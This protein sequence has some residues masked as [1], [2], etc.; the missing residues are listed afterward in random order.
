MPT[1]VR[2]LTT[3]A[4]IAAFVL[5]VMALLIYFVEPRRSEV[6]IE[7]PLRNLQAEPQDGARGDGA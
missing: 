3:I 6:V 1:L 7:V 2:L 4:L 5:T